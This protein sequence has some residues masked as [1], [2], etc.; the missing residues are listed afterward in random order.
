MDEKSIFASKTFW[1]NVLA[2]AVLLIGV[3]IEQNASNPV[4]PKDWEGWLAMV[5]AAAN[6]V[7]RFITSQPV[8]V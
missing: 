6:V 7:L 5:L 8:K 1:T 2:L 3:V 4:L